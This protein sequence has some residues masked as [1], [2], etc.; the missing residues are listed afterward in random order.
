MSNLI[1]LTKI[2]VIGTIKS[3]TNSTKK[4]SAAVLLFAL[5]FGYIGFSIFNIAS[6]MMDGFKTLNAPYLLLAQFMVFTSSFLLLSNIYRAGGTL[7][8]FKDYDLLM[9]LPI[10][11][12]TIIL[13]KVIILYLLSLF[14][15]MLFMIPAFI[16]YAIAVK[17]SFVFCLLFFITLFI[18]PMVPLVISTIIGT[19]IFGLSSKFKHKNIVNYIITFGL[20]GTLMYFSSKMGSMNS[21]DMANIGKSMVNMFNRIYPLTKLYLDIVSNSNILSLALYI[22]IP[23]L[24]FYIFIKILIKLYSRI[25][26]NLSSY[27]KNTK[28]K[29]TSMKRNSAVK[30]LYLKE[31]KRYFSSVNYVMNTGIGAIM[32]TFSIFGIIIFGGEKVNAIL[33]IPGFS[34]VL[35][36]LGP[37]VMGAFCLLTCTTGPSISLE[38]K[39]LWIIKSIPAKVKEIF[40]SKILVNLTILI[41]TIIINSIVLSI[42]FKTGFITTIFMFVTPFIYSLFISIL[43]IVINLWFPNFT[44]KNE[45]KVI[46]QSMST[47]LAIMIGMALAIIPFTIK[48]TMN[49]NLYTTLITSI[50]LLLTI[51]LYTYMTT[52]GVKIFNKLN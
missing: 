43:G 40:Y 5:L 15:T 52:I 4:T 31:L 9:S 50:M 25:N 36:N 27:K 38:G 47:F 14:N 3:F 13:S 44:W 45:I 46:K 19:A 7:F 12:E 39:N 2:N 49:P 22:F 32:L 35:K 8:K 1:S 34:D 16:A 20:F 24:L 29:L 26:D 10:K 42:Y 51:G 37:L 21:M 17:I 48:T 33:G 23:I 18:I 30:A 41:P 11:K 28:Y 6:L